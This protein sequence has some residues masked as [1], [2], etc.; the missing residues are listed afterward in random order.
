MFL[1]GLAK[2][3]H[4]R[5]RIIGTDQKYPAVETAGF[6]TINSILLLEP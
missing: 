1:K 6:T 3:H 5:D 2:N 4:Y